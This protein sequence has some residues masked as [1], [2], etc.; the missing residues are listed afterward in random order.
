MAPSKM[1]CNNSDKF[2][3]TGKEMSPLGIGHCADVL[4][5]GV[6]MMGRDD[7]IWIV[8]VKNSHK[9]WIRAPEKPES[10][11]EDESEDETRTKSPLHADSDSQ[12]A[13]DEATKPVSSSDSDEVKPKKT[14]PKKTAAKAKQPVAPVKK[15]PD[16]VVAKSK[17]PKEKS[18]E[19]QEGYEM[20]GPDG[21]AYV[22]KADKNGKH[23]WTKVTGRALKKAPSKSKKAE[24]EEEEDVEVEAPL[25]KKERAKRGPTAYNRFIGT[26]MKKLREQHPDKHTTYYLQTAVAMWNEMTDDEKKAIAE[27]YAN[28]EKEDEEETPVPTTKPAKPTAYNTFIKSKTHELRE[29]EPGLKKTEYM[30]RAAA[31]WKGMSDDEKK[32]IVEAI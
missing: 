30:K 28:A 15:A 6:K 8:G 4:G 14:V 24:E 27:Q 9:V 19:Y 29:E 1:K 21:T 26:T 10:E 16:A 2:M 12:S 17:P 3:Y 22:V 5:V 11:S 23:R 13:S 7:K 18:S 25:P 32:A 20:A 31:I